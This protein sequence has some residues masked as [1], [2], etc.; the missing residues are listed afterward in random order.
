[1][2]LVLDVGNTNSAIGVYDNNELIGHWRLTTR[3][4]RTADEFAVL[5]DSLLRMQKLSLDSIQDVIISCVVPPILPFIEEMFTAKLN[6]KPLI[7]GPGIKTGISIKIENPKEV[8]ADRIVNAVAALE[9]FNEQSIVIDF[10]TA[11]TFDVVSKKGEYLGGLIFPGITISAEALYSHAAKLPRIEI[12]QPSA[13]IGKNTIQSIQS[14]IFYGYCELV[15]GLI[16]RIKNS[17][18]GNTR[19][20]ASGGYAKLLGKES[21][22]IDEIVPLL[23]LEGLRIIYEKNR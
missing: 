6:L 20:I 11:T 18:T 21:S 17:L 19:V 13:V 5:L 7:V 12:V 23:T 4:H 15:D 14:G 10:G 2:L 1:M 8:G 22:G 3:I 16:K 9:M